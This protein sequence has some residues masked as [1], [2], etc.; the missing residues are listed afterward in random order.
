MC[1][2]LTKFILF[3]TINIIVVLES[4]DAI[5]IKIKIKI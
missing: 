2:D 5:K 4:I 1:Y 3:L